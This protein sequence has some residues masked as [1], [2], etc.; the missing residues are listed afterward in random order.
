MPKFDVDSE[1]TESTSSEMMNHFAELQAKLT[2]VR[3]KIDGLLAEGYRTPAAQQRFQPFFE[4]FAR[5]FD[6]VNQ[7]LE[8]IGQY[9]RNVG[10]AFNET[11]N[12]LGATLSR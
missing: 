3:S 6:Q 7:S 5:G 8:G 9:V 1:A 12:Q 2:V 4:E 11:D 10:Q